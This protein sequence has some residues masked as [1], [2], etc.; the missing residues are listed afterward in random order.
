MTRRPPSRPPLSARTGAAGG[1]ASERAAARRRTAAAV[2]LG[3]SLGAAAAF[4]GA[5]LQPR[6]RAGYDPRR[7]G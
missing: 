5:L 2:G 4:V 1:P 3:L 7:T 6:R